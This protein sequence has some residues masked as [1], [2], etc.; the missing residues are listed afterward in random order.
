MANHLFATVPGFTVS[1]D[2]SSTVISFDILK[3]PIN[4][5]WGS[6]HPTS[7]VGVTIQ[8]QSNPSLTATGTLSATTV[9]L[10]FSAAF[11]DLVGVFIDFRF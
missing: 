7:I 4:V 10:T 11:S 8:S 9:T 1:G 6:N 3:A 2:G 5:P